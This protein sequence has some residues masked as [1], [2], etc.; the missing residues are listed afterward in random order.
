M[1]TPNQS[2]TLTIQLQ[3][4]IEFELLKRENRE[5]KKEVTR[6]RL[7]LKKSKESEAFIKVIEG[8]PIY[9]VFS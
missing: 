6:L 2:D 4:S 7:A 9:K 1:E 3:K 5:L 8:T